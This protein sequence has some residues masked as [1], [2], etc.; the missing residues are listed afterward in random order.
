M[1]NHYKYIF[2]TEEN[3]ICFQCNIAIMNIFMLH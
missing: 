2:I 3:L 1:Y